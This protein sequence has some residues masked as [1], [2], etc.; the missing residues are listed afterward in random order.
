MATT[1]SAAAVQMRGAAPQ[2]RPHEAAASPAVMLADS[3]I[4]S[5]GEIFH[6][7]GL[8]QDVRSGAQAVVKVLKGRELGIPPIE[9]MTAINIIKGKVTLS[10]G[11][12]ASAIRRAGKYRFIVTELADQACAID[13]YEKI[14]RTWELQGTSRFT[15][16]DARR[17]EVA[18][19][20]NWRKYPRNMLFARALS[21]GARWFCSDVVSGIYTPDELGAL[22]DED[23]NLAV[24]PDPADA[25]V[26]RGGAG[27]AVQTARQTSATVAPVQSEAVSAAPAA[28]EMVPGAQVTPAPRRP[29]A[30]REQVLRLKPRLSDVALTALRS[31]WSDPTVSDDALAIHLRQIAVDL[32]APDRAERTPRASGSGRSHGTYHQ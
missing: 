17:A 5:L 32:L 26:L 13:F 11:A 16:E 8:F 9:A 25:D 20:D 12:M 6:Q 7:S 10:A 2:Q 30:L 29:D 28:E 3:N 4:H 24:T 22:E 23:G 31:L 27:E 14:G 15:I 18:N 1:T 19:G 21:N